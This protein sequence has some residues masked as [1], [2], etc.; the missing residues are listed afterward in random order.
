MPWPWCFPSRQG[1][2]KTT[3]TSPP[4]SD[5]TGLKLLYD[6]LAPKVDIVAVH[7]LGGHRENSWTAA[8]GVNWLRD[9]LPSDMLNTRVLSWGYSVPTR[10]NSQQKIS[11]QL[12]Y[13]L[14]KL[15]SSTYTANR[16]I[17][18]IAHSLGGPLVKSALLYADSVQEPH[19]L[20]VRSIK[21]S[22][23][24][25]IFMG[26]PELDSRLLGLQSYLA[27]ARDSEQ[28]SSDIYKEA[29]WL[30]TTLQSYPSISQEF[31]SL[32]VH[33]RSDFMSTN[34]TLDQTASSPLQKSLSHICI[35]ADH[36][37]MIKFESSLDE[38]YLKIK[39]H[40]VCAAEVLEQETDT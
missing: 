33:E 32:F 28:E 16:P 19:V 20:D 9:L 5:E 1:Q 35:Q 14:W 6:G 24:G 26:T 25:V 22:T 4:P 34:I 11:E 29:Q 13:D 36:G 15:R 3:K 21:S 27:T 2:P 30:V 8:N 37:G 39:E 12:V 18:F 7:G 38:G 31:W 17:I 23:H 10:E 40:L